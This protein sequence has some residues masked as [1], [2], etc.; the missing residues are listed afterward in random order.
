[1]EIIVNKL[2][3]DNVIKIKEQE[4]YKCE[5]KILSNEEYL[6][7]LKY[8]LHNMSIILKNTEDINESREI[9]AE[10]YEIILALFKNTELNIDK[11]AEVQIKKALEKGRYDQKIFLQRINKEE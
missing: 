5:Y 6:T 1:M 9:L 7:N 10:I 11:V 4:G 2:V 3:R 8:N